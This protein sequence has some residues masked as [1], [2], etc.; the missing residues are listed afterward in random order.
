VPGYVISPFVSAG[1]V[2][3][4]LLD[5][6]SVLR[7]LGDKFGN[8]SYSPLV[9]ARPVQSLSAVFNFDQPIANPPAAPSLAG[10][11]AG[12][13]PAPAGATV[14]APKTPLQQGFQDAIT[15][16]KQNGAGPDH[17]KFGALLQQV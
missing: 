5:H 7:F 10:Y 14:P 12:R 11:L 4:S 8:R 16:M 1:S 3:H 2:N 15:R 13:P 6:T 9:D 17:P